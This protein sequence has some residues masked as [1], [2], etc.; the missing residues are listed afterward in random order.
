MKWV[1]QRERP[2]E[3]VSTSKEKSYQR[4]VERE[5]LIWKE[6]FEAQMWTRLER[7]K[8]PNRLKAFIVVAGELNAI[9]LYRAGILKAKTKKQF[10]VIP[11]IPSIS[12]MREEW[13][14]KPQK[15]MT[16]DRI[17]KIRF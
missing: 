5:R 16:E 6:G 12:E 1:H 7:I 9:S 4:M 10:W 15:T 3:K 2:T 8:N 13:D 11:R 14:G 17:R